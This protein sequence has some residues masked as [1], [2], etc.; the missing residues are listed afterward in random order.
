MNAFNLNGED[1]NTFNS[2]Y[3]N[4]ILRRNNINQTIGQGFNKTAL[5]SAQSKDAIIVIFSNELINKLRVF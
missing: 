5:N 2:D 3:I 1:N 4:G